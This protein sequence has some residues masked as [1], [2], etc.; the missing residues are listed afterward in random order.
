MRPREFDSLLR[1]RPTILRQVSGTHEYV[2]G[3]HPEAEDVIVS[4]GFSGDGPAA[5]RP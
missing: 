3:P 2:I 1:R 4:T 5:L